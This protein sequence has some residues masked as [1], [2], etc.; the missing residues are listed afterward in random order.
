MQDLSIEIR[1]G[2]SIRTTLDMNLDGYKL[3]DGYYPETNESAWVTDKFDLIITGT[4]ES[5]LENKIRAVELAL[6]FAASHSTGPDGVWILYAPSENLTPWQSRITGGAVL[7]DRNMSLGWKNLRVPAQ[8]VVERMPFWET[9]SPVTLPVSNGGG[10]SGA[11]VNHGDTDAGHD[12]YL[13]I[14]DTAVIGSLPAP[15]IIEY[16]NTTNDVRM[17]DNLYIGHFVQSK[18]YNPPAESNL[19]LE[20]SGTLDAACSGGAYA[21]LTWIG[22]GE[23]QLTSWSLATALLGQRYYKL[24]AR[25][26]AGFAYTDLWL[27][28]RLMAGSLELAKTRWELMSP[29]RELQLIGTL[30][31]PPFRHGTYVDLGNLTVTL[32]EKRA[33]GNGAIN[34]DYIALLPQDSWRQ[35]GALSGLAYNEKLIDNPVEESLVTLYGASYKVTHMVEAG[36]PVMLRPGVKNILYF[37]HDTDNGTAAIARTAT[38]A[39]KYHPRRLTV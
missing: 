19:V 24:A 21:A 14:A 30:Q 2:S 10:S 23:N 33:G 31:I 20:G 11:I 28:A 4:S 6:D 26:Q 37:L 1:A 22:T 38:V 39:I 8:V 36:A 9:T 29:N 16:L 15:A 13:E 25:F 32:H 12:F 5:D 17:V 35:F 3:L 18:P 27:Q 7:H 34:L